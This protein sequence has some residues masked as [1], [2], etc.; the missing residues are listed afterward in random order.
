MLERYAAFSENCSR[1]QLRPGETATV[2]FALSAR[3]RSIWDTD[4][5]E[6]SE[7]LG[8]FTV[9]VGSS[10]RDRRAVG[11]FKRSPRRSDPGHTQRN[12]ASDWHN[13]GAI[14]SAAHYYTVAV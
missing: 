13:L 10:S 5:H 6:W 12:T 1:M 7:V 3:D 4:R 9:A 14:N 8:L 11:A 2:R